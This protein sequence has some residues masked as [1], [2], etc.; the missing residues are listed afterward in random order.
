M[1]DLSVHAYFGTGIVASDARLMPWKHRTVINSSEAVR[2]L[3]N[4][5]PPLRRIADSYWVSF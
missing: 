3:S 4:F 2:K 1:G 5:I